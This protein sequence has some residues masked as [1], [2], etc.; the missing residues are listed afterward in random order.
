M[1]PL[2]AVSLTS[3][4]TCK[5]LD[6]GQ[7]SSSSSV[8]AGTAGHPAVFLLAHVS[9]NTLLALVQVKHQPNGHHR[10]F[11][12][13]AHEGMLD[14]TL[15]FQGVDGDKIHYVRPVVIAHEG[16]IGS[17]KVSARRN[18]LGEYD[19]ESIGLHVHDTGAEESISLVVAPPLAE[20]TPLSL[21]EE[22]LIPEV[23]QVDG[24]VTQLSRSDAQ[25]KSRSQRLVNDPDNPGKR[26]TEE[27]LYNRQLRRLP[28]ADPNNPGQTISR[29]DKYN[30]VLVEDTDNPGQMIARNVRNNRAYAKKQVE[31]PDNPG[32]TI[33]QSQKKNREKI[34]DPENPG[35]QMTRAAFDARNYRRRKAE[36]AK[37]GQ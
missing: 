4:L 22:E 11:G 31:D 13:L 37:T 32:Q 36:R 35:K 30:R 3:H 5:A 18:E 8:S 7:V 19:V 14:G 29:N 21:P 33:S 6:A 25:G 27:Q 2:H 15:Q 24:S 23:P 28:V 26:M 20:T 34:D 10:L 12:S 17:L 9:E 1:N 16:G